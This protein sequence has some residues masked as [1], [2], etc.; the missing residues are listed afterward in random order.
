[1]ENIINKKNKKENENTNT[2]EKETTDPIQKIIYEF[3]KNYKII[4]LIIIVVIIISY[5]NSKPIGYFKH[6]RVVS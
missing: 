5:N 3:K 2:N 4:I 1:M 6:Q